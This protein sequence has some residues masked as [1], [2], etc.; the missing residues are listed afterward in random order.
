MRISLFFLLGG[1]GGGLLLSFTFTPHAQA[2]AQAQA[3]AQAQDA[4]CPICAGVG[5]FVEFLGE[6]VTDALISGA[7][8]LKGAFFEA[9][10]APAPA[11]DNNNI[12][13]FEVF[14]DV[15][16]RQPPPPEPPEPSEPEPEPEPPPQLSPQQNAD[17]VDDAADIELLYLA[18]SIPPAA[19]EGNRC[20]LQRTSVSRSYF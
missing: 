12:D 2:H 18:P 10:P 14:L 16:E 20:D 8:A 17:P 19:Q 3:Q 13:P 5:N 4:D 6:Q 7:S 15:P 9:A 11:G 1:P